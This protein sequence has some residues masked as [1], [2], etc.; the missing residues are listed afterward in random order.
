LIRADLAEQLEG[1]VFSFDSH[2]RDINPA[3]RFLN[4][5]KPAA[6]S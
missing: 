4:M 1:G 5:A 2:L 6:A 3:W